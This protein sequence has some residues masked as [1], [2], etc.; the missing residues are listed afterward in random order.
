[1]AAFKSKKR[2]KI[3]LM[4]LYPFEDHLPGTLAYVGGAKIVST[5][6]QCFLG[7]LPGEITWKPEINMEQVKNLKKVVKNAGGKPTPYQVDLM[8]YYQWKHI[9]DI[10]KRP[11]EES[12]QAKVLEN[13]TWEDWADQSKTVS[14]PHKRGDIR[15]KDYPYRGKPVEGDK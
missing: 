10:Q 9:N 13:F 1:M 8:R 15:L 2:G 6:S 12:Y 14:N 11:L 4:G 7:M 3:V 5:I